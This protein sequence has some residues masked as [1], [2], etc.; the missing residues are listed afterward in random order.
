MR[1]DF[2]EQRSERL[3]G[4]LVLGHEAAR[5]AARDQLRRVRP[6]AARGEDDRGRVAVAGEPRGDVEAVEVGELDVE[7]DD[8]RA[9]PAR[10]GERGRAVGGLAD[11]LVALGLEQQPRPGAEA[12]VVVDDEDGLDMARLSRSAGALPI[13]ITAPWAAALRPSRRLL[14]ALEPGP[15]AGTLGAMEINPV[16]GV[17]MDRT[18]ISSRAAHWAAKH[19]R[20]A[21][22]GWIA[23]VA[24]AFLIGGSVGT[25]TI[26]DED[27]GNG[28]SR[29][30]EQIIADAGFPDD[31]SESVLV[32]GENGQTIDDPQ[33]RAAIGDVEQRLAQVAHVAESSRR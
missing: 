1:S 24:V 30:G 13:R 10:L 7:Q 28:D 27:L 18:S 14:A 23:F 20:A 26:A 32:Q 5:A 2:T 33:F 8:V 25:K 17:T 12:G 11:D 22:L 19:R 31:D 21:I 4:E 16:K 29:T 6:V 15:R 3:A 9:Q